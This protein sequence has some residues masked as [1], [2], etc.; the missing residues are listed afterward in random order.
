MDVIQKHKLKKLA[1]HIDLSSKSLETID[2]YK[3]IF[4]I[5]NLSCNC[6]QYQCNETKF[7]YAGNWLQQHSEICQAI[8]EI[9]SV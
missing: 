1:P 6:N 3:W 7:S 2:H 4:F 9:M 8:D 5:E